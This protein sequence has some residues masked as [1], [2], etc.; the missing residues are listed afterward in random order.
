MKNNKGKEEEKKSIPDSKPIIS[1]NIPAYHEEHYIIDTLIELTKQTVWPQAEIVIA[2]YNPEKSS[3]NSNNL[4]DVLSEN[5]ILQGPLKVEKIRIIDV[6]RRGI[7]YAR[8][9]AARSSKGHYITCFDA[10]SRFLTHDAIYK[11]VYPIS[12]NQALM[13]HCQVL[14]EPSEVSPS[15]FTNVAYSIRNVVERYVPWAPIVFEQ[16]MTFPMDIYISSGGFRDVVDK[17]GW[18]LAFDISLR[19]GYNQIK[20]LDEVTILTS[21]R[22]DTGMFLDLD[23]TTAY[24]G[25]QGLK[26]F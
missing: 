20:M 5:D 19:Y 4:R 18:F 10:D 11:L 16:G 17:E 15:S 21:A 12:I 26:I 6:P 14:L 8:D 3:T 24:R 2:E 9:I 25:G 23:Y 13:T 22:R 7:G 1:I